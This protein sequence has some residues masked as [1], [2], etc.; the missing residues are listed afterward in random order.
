MS[1]RGKGEFDFKFLR[2]LLRYYLIQE[3][4]LLQQ[5]KGGEDLTAARF[6]IY[7]ALSFWYTLFSLSEVSFWCMARGVILV[8]DW[9]WGS[10]WYIVRNKGVLVQD[11]E[12][13]RKSRNVS[14]L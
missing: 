9:T 6:L 14:F 8:Q 5:E 2:L 10:F 7:E 1:Q 3:P 13:F 11:S 4:G 12:I